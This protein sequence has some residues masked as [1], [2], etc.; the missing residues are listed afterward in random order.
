MKRIQRKRTKGYRQPPNTKY[1]GRPTKWG[2]PFLVEELGA[3]EA[4]RRYKEC[5]LNNTMCYVYFYEIKASV[6]YDRFKWMAENL[7]Q[8]RKYDY[9]SCFCPLDQPCHVDVL[10]RLLNEKE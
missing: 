6:Q 5:I 9:L 3:E 4:V 10:I 7:E 2:N 8:L 1:C